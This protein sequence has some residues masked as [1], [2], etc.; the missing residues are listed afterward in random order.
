VGTIARL[1]LALPTVEA[2]ELTVADEL[3]FGTL[4]ASRLVLLF[5]LLFNMRRGFRIPFK[6]VLLLAGKF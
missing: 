4:H 2:S 6:P 1:A 5:V 3:L